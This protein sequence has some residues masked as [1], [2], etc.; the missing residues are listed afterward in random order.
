MRS[1]QRPYKLSERLQK[2][3]LSP[4]PD[5][6]L[7]RAIAFGID[8]T[9]TFYNMFVLT[10]CER[11]ARADRT[12][13]EAQRIRRARERRAYLERSDLAC[14]A[15][16]SL[17]KIWNLS[18]EQQAKILEVTEDQLFA[19]LTDPAETPLAS[20]HLARVFVLVNIFADIRAFYGA[21]GPADQWLHRNNSEFEGQT[22]LA[23][24][25]DRSSGLQEVRRYTRGMAG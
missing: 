17:A 16:R 23:W 13:A 6:A 12:I 14:E 4:P 20:D 21:E 25:L 24:M 2:H 3:L 5:S 1:D 15:F 18:W 19:W 9:I 7:S 8:P 22:P 11:L 10:P